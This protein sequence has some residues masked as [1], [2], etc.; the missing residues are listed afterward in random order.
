VAL[1]RGILVDLQEHLDGRSA[2][3]TVSQPTSDQTTRTLA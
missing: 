1:T 3:P 2:A